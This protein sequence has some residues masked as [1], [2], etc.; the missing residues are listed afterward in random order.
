MKDLIRSF[1]KEQ[2]IEEDMQNVIKKLPELNR[3]PF[4]SILLEMIED[5]NV[6]KDDL[7]SNNK[8]FFK[9]LKFRNILVHKGKIENDIDFQI[10]TE[11]LQIFVERLLLR[12]LNWPAKNGSSADNHSNLDALD[13][14]HIYR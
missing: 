1:C 14:D 11:K 8:E 9:F 6:K 3:P 10:C 5:Y 4:K 12:I 13:S 7:Y 2:E